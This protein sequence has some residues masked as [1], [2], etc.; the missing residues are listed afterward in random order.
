M[1][2]NHSC[3]SPL[4]RLPVRSLG[5]VRSITKNAVDILPSKIHLLT[6]TLSVIFLQIKNFLKETYRE[7]GADLHPPLLLC[8]LQKT[9]QN[10]KILDIVHAEPPFSN[11]YLPTN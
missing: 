1:L 3:I 10:S 9:E 5:R 4:L 8:S 2:R 7:Q 6:P 11:F